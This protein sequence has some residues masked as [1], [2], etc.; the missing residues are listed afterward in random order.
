M[1]KRLNN[2][3]ILKK[4]HFPKFFKKLKASRDVSNRTRALGHTSQST[5]DQPLNYVELMATW[6]DAFELLFAV[7][8]ICGALSMMIH[9]DEEPAIV[10]VLCSGLLVGIPWIFGGIATNLFRACRERFGKYLPIYRHSYSAFAVNPKK[11]LPRLARMVRCRDTCTWLTIYGAVVILV[12]D[13]MCFFDLQLLFLSITVG[14]IW[15][16]GGFFVISLRLISD[17]FREKHLM[18]QLF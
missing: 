11:S 12:G 17:I 10:S 6:C 15:S 18:R 7:T 16:F 14:A 13:L 4:L 1:S 8:W 2:P 3:K 9:S 5:A